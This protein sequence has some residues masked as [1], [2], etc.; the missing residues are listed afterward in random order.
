MSKSDACKTQ[1]ES[2]SGRLKELVLQLQDCPISERE[3]RDLHMRLQQLQERRGRHLET[4]INIQGI[5]PHPSSF[6]VGCLKSKETS[7][8]QERALPTCVGKQ[9]GEE[10]CFPGDGP[11]PCSQHGCSQFHRNLHGFCHRHKRLRFKW[12]I[13]SCFQMTL[14]GLQLLMLLLAQA[15][16]EIED[17]WLL[18][19]ITVSLIPLSVVFLNSFAG[20]TTTSLF[21]ILSTCIFGSLVFAAKRFD[22]MQRTLQQLLLQTEGKYLQVFETTL[23]LE[24]SELHGRHCSFSTLLGEREGGDELVSGVNFGLQQPL[25]L[26][27][28]HSNFEEAKR[29]LPIFQRMVCD[30]LNDVAIA[31]V[32]ASIKLLT[33]LDRQKSLA[34]VLYCKVFCDGLLQ[35]QRAWRRL[36]ELTGIYVVASQDEFAKVSSQ[37]CCRIVVSVQGYQATVFLM[38]ASLSKLE[39]ELYQIHHDANLLGLLDQANPRYWEV[40]ML[41]APV[42]TPS[43]C[44]VLISFLRYAAQILSAAFCYYFCIDSLISDLSMRSATDAALGLPFLVLVVVFARELR[45]LLF[46]PCCCYCR[47]PSHRRR[48]KPTQIFYR[49]YFGVQGSLYDITVAMLQVCTVVLQAMGKCQMLQ[50]LGDRQGGQVLWSQNSFRCFVALLCLNSI[51]PALILAFSD[52]AFS[53]VGAAFMD[54]GLD[55]G[56]IILWLVVLHS[57][58]KITNFSSLDAFELLVKLASLTF[59]SYMSVYVSIAHVCCVCR[60]LQQIDWVMLQMPY[61]QKRSQLQR[62]IRIG[63]SVIYSSALLLTMCLLL[64]QADPD[65]CSPCHCT[66]LNATAYHLE[67]CGPV[68]ELGLRNLFLSSHKIH[69]MAP[70]ALKG[71]SSLEELDLSNNLLTQLPATVFEDLS[72]LRKLKLQNNHLETLP[73]GILERPQLL[74]SLDLTG[75]NF[76]TLPADSFQNLYSLETLHLQNNNLQ[77]LPA[78]IFENLSTLSE[79]HLENN[80]LQKLP[81]GVFQNLSSLLYLHLEN[82]NLETLPAGIFEGLKNLQILDLQSNGLKT[83]PAGVFSNLRYLQRLSLRNSGLDML[84]SRA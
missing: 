6:S 4:W 22:S 73:A 32:A 47:R 23:R 58:D 35:V 7:E 55:L 46:I 84:P 52:R 5:D 25:S 67:H 54:A 80:N 34:D 82:N 66:G 59:W 14:N 16:L 21:T 3:K 74:Q 64:G 24:E 1:V 42:L 43:W 18:I 53:R 17:R 77:T 36:H 37:K 78:G 68:A 60:S 8:N 12:K 79:L 38:E 27:D 19:G 62:Y 45:F 33:D 70:D 56:Y 81:A 9:L 28:L 15:S 30:Q 48:P 51:Y 61:N 26:S 69:S 39:E 63:C 10:G 44:V 40:S 2:E 57:L 49:K 72:S 71:L 83:L 76:S 20:P 50:V 29:M 31:H 41:Q 75:N 11:F 13:L 65:N